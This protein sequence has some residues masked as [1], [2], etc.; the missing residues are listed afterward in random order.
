MAAMF[1]T[2]VQKDR[3]RYWPL[4]LTLQ[5]RQILQVML[6]GSR[7]QF[8]HRCDSRHV[9]LRTMARHFILNLEIIKAFPRVESVCISGT[10]A[11]FSGQNTVA[12]V[13]GTTWSMDLLLLMPCIA[14][15]IF[16]GRIAVRIVDKAFLFEEIA[17]ARL[18]S[19]VDLDVLLA[20]LKGIVLN[21]DLAI[22]I[23]LTLSN[24]YIV[25]DQ[26]N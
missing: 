11:L 19:L 13:I 23:T 8:R 9:R 3:I 2:L 12:T 24:A 25:L 14:A 15:I 20:A 5:W 18:S 16:L 22:A 17:A 10:S 7:L 26:A 1:T 4:S 21:V 6:S